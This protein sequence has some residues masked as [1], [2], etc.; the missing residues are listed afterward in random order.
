MF[1]SIYKSSK[2]TSS[3]KLNLYNNK[4]QLFENA[5]LIEAQH[6]PCVVEVVHPV[7]VLHLQSVSEKNE[8]GGVI[9][10]IKIKIMN[11]ESF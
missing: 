5:E 7:Q 1:S 10:I 11:Y 3:Q 2:H 6:V 4:Y 9:I 8:N